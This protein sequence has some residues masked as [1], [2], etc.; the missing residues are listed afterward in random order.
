M[1]DTVT[2]A[3][4]PLRYEPS[5]LL[6]PANLVTMLRIAAAPLAFWMIHDSEELN[7]WPLVAVW[8]VLSISDLIDGRLARRQGPTRAG[9]FLDPLADKVLVWGGVAMMCI[10]GRFVWLAWVLIVARDLAVSAFRSYYA[11]R[12][13]AVPASKLA[14]W[15]AFLQLG[16]VGWVTLPPTHDLDWLADGTLWAGIAAGLISGAQYFLAGSRSTT[17]MVR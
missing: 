2:E 12:G 4:S 3:K 16:A 13:L 11:K 9:A 8:F 5:D 14:K 10:E 7:S 6:T 17:T 1:N 15:K